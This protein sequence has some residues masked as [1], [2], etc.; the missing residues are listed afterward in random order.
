VVI[1]LLVTLATTVGTPCY[2]AL[3]AVVPATVAAE[4]LGPANGIL[5]TIETA[6]WVVGPAAGGVLLVASSHTIALSVNAVLFAVG[7]LCLLPTRSRQPA[8][9]TEST[10]DARRS[11]GRELHEG[12]RTIVGSADI[13][14]PLLLVVVVNVILG[15]AS[16]GLVLVA[17]RLVDLGEGG[18]AVLNA[19]LG[20]GGFA[21]IAFTSRI[22]RGR[23]PLTSLTT[24][25]ICGSAPFALLAVVHVP[26]I[27]IALMVLAGA[28]SVVT[29]VVATTILLRSL[30]QAVI[31]RVF[32]IIDS[33][34]VASIL[35][36]TLAAPVLIDLAG[37]R[38][39][40]VIVGS[41]LP[42]TV[43]AG[44]HQWRRLSGRAT[45]RRVDVDSRV[46]LLNRQPWLAD[47]LPVVLEMLAA[48]ASEE[49]VAGGQVVIRQGD[50]ADDFFVLISGSLVVTKSV[51]GE[52]PVE[53][54][55]LGP[56]EGF[57]EIGLLGGVPRTATVAAAESATILRIRGDQFVAAVNAAPASADASV[58]AG[59]V[60]RLARGSG[61]HD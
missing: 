29:E 5:S 19:S 6:S 10:Q 21:G 53:V 41:I 33:V 9:T 60:A 61:I 23:R 32:G 31:A 59:L 57:G 43:I 20:I 49:P 35:A 34:L 16:V 22:S 56:G 15:G 14:V 38:A 54:N 36:G 18:F 40:L 58:G 4:D 30:P 46:Q 3:A 48:T 7:A 51:P 13:A 8:P 27:V 44:A 52:A 17:E 12:V 37:L 11:V 2:P 39:T 47:V 26:W 50:V 55:R 42:A 45:Q 1:V 28:G 24:A 25:A